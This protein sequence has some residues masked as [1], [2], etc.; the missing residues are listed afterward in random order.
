MQQADTTVRHANAHTHT[1]THRLFVDSDKKLN[2]QPN[3]RKFEGKRRKKCFK[4]KKS[5]GRMIISLCF[6]FSVKLDDLEVGVT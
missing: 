6:F 3:V 1:H 4:S 5:I 2:T